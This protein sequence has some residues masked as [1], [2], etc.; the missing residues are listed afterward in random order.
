MVTLGP[1][2]GPMVDGVGGCRQESI[3][4]EGGRD[5]SGRM[6]AGDPHGVR[7]Q[8]LRSSG[9]R[10]AMVSFQWIYRGAPVRRRRGGDDGGEFGA[11]G[12]QGCIVESG[13]GS[14]GRW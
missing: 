7:E 3:P 6:A 8:P 2:V 11:V 5:D 9:A 12:Q 13:D 4:R 1:L 10:D 14:I